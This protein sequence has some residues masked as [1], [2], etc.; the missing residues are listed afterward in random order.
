MQRNWVLNGPFGPQRWWV[1]PVSTQWRHCGPFKFSAD[2][3]AFKFS[4][5]DPPACLIIPNLKQHNY[6]ATCA[7]GGASL[8]EGNDDSMIIVGFINH[9]F[10]V[11]MWTVQGML[12]RTK[13]QQRLPVFDGILTWN[14]MKMAQVRAEKQKKALKIFE[15]CQTQIECHRSVMIDTVGLY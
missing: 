1:A 4:W 8:K 3:R 6:S 11:S 13:F 10:I 15:M 2:Y 7:Y 5:F 12:S 14:E 9:N